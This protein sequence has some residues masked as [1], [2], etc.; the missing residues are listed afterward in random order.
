M[1]LPAPPLRN[2]DLNLL[3]VFDVVMAERSL[4]RAAQVFAL[5]QP[6]VLNAFR[7]LLPALCPFLFTSLA[8]PI[9]GELSE[10]GVL[11]VEIT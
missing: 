10:C 11:E 7:R 3:K 1:T 9:K 2:F 5:T 4:T 8:F 6:P